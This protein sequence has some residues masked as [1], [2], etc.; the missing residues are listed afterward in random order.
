MKAEPREGREILFLG[1]RLLAEQQARLTPD[2]HK[3]GYPF[4]LEWERLSAA[5]QR[6]K[7]SPE[8]LVDFMAAL[9]GLRTPEDLWQLAEGSVHYNMCLVGYRPESGPDGSPDGD[10]YAQTGPTR[11]NMAAQLVDQMLCDAAE[12][13][14]GSDLENLGPVDS[15]VLLG[16]RAVVDRHHALREQGLWFVYPLERDWLRLRRKLRRPSKFD[17]P[18]QDR[19]EAE[20]FVAWVESCAPD[21]LVQAMH[22]YVFEGLDWAGRPRKA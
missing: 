10:G 17:D 19:A 18:E 8:L 4:D 9:S 7:A 12:R 1:R 21:D 14:G 2:G 13:G 15:L 11:S 5:Y 22:R 20:R 6:G 16:D 3:P